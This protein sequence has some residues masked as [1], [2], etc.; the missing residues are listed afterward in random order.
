M[1]K[2]LVALVATFAVVEMPLRRKPTVVVAVVVAILCEVDEKKAYLAW[3]EYVRFISA[4]SFMLRLL[5]LLHYIL[6]A[7][8]E[9]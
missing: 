5:L 3:K 1:F 8:P 9:V 7:M 4:N 2:T 6:F